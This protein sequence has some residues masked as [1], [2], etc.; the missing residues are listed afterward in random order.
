LAEV[1]RLAQAVTEEF[2]LIGL[3]GVDFVL[4]DARPVVVEVNPRYSASMELVERATGIPVFDLH[5][6]A[7][8]GRM[9]PPATAEAPLPGDGFHA[10]AIV[11]ASKPVS[12][13]DTSGW[14]ERGVRDVPHPGEAIRSGHPIC[15]VL[16]SGS[17]RV[18]CLAT[19]QAEE[20]AILEEC[21]A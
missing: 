9:P 17:S 18:S 16:A 14:I 15:T 5:R 2:G 6:A 3:N 12:V 10:K 13:P 1:R 19:L 4:R 21:A 11:Y 7:C 20:A 8:E